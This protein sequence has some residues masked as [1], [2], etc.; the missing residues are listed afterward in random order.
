MRLRGGD[1]GDAARADEPGS[2]RVSGARII[3]WPRWP[4]ASLASA[5]LAAPN[6]K[7]R[8]SEQG[9]DIWPREQQTPEALAA[10]HKAETEKWWPI[11]KASNL[12]AE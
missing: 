4:L 3:E 7:Q 1:R 2:G 12:K 6:V 8:L 9:H 5:A 11:V 10:Y